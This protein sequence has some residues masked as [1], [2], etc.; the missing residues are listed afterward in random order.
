MYRK[1]EEVRKERVYKNMRNEI[2]GSPKVIR[3][4]DLWKVPAQLIEESENGQIKL[5]REKQIT[6]I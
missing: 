2:L 4:M 5:E 3:L 1:K 6:E